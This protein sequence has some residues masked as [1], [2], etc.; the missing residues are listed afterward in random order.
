MSKDLINIIVLLCIF[1]IFTMNYI[2]LHLYEELKIPLILLLLTLFIRI[3]SFLYQ[4]PTKYF[5]VDIMLSIIVILSL[6][7][8]ATI[9]KYIVI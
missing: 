5:L 6:Y 7:K 2:H 4:V 3:Y 8:Y 9:K 1:I